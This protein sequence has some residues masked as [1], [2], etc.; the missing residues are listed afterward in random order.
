MKI[1]EWKSELWLPSPPETLFAFFGDAANLDAL[2]PD[3]LNFK[4]LTPMPM[5]IREGSLIVYRLRIRG[6]PV[7]WRTRINVWD[8]P[9]RFIDEQIRG[10]YRLW[11]HEHTFIPDR[12]GTLVTDHVRYAVPFDRLV[13]SWLVRP[14]IETIFAFRSQALQA[15][16]AQ[17][18]NAPGAAPG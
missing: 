8:P 10:P 11:V 2:T 6:F 12:G 14:D 5:Q 17:S 15:R 18:E 16:F 4:I 13:H 1:R 3:W 9:H 7:R